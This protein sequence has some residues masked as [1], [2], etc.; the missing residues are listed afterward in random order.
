MQ[1]DVVNALWA[2]LSGNAEL[3]L[4]T[5]ILCRLIANVDRDDWDAAMCVVLC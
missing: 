1:T 2:T 5:P 4:V 3:P